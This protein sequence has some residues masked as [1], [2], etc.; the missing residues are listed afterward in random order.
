MLALLT[1]FLMTLSL[2]QAYNSKDFV[3]ALKLAQE[4][5]LKLALHIAEVSGDRDAKEY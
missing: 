5:G 4:N 2:F 3:P 1:E